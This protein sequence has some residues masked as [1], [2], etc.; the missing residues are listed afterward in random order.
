M[1]EYSKTR[2]QE[3][4]GSKCCSKCKE[5]KDI[6]EFRLK[7]LDL[8]RK[9]SVSQHSSH[10]RSCEAKTNLSDYYKN[11]EI[12]KEYQRGYARKQRELIKQGLLPQKESS[13]YSRRFSK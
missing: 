4:S 6:L 11:R 1:K 10:C 2:L 7:T 3:I 9:Q 8:K 12:K 5:Y 13:A